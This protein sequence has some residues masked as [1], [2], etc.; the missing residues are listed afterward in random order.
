MQVLPFSFLDVVDA[1]SY[2]IMFNHYSTHGFMGEADIEIDKG[3]KMGAETGGSNE[4]KPG[5][6][7]N[8]GEFRLSPDGKTKIVMQEVSMHWR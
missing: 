8:Q 3:V 6:Q 5:Q 2:D 1:T 4:L 7:I